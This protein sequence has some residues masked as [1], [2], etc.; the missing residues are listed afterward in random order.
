MLDLLEKLSRFAPHLMALMLWS[1]RFELVPSVLM[2]VLNL[3]SSDFV[4]FLSVALLEHVLQ[5]YHLSSS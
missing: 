2:S 3:V 5:L 1:S 4:F